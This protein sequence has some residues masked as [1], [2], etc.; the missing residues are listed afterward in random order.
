MKALKR[1]FVTHL[2]IKIYRNQ[3]VIENLDDEV[4]ARSFKAE[5]P[6]TTQRLLVGEFKIAE[7]CLSQAIKE[8]LPGRWLKI[9]PTVLFQP[10]EMIEGGLSF[11]ET[12]CLEELCQGAGAAKVV[13]WVGEAL[14]RNQ[15]LAK[16]H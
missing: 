15:A 3:F 6:F 1:W 11:V 8:T 9:A 10:M 13:L 16:L 14:D 12:R 7:E 2:Y 4:P 5:K